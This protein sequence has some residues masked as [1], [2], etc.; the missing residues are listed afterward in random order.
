MKRN[1]HGHDQLH[2]TYSFHKGHDEPMPLSQ[3]ACARQSWQLMWQHSEQ[4]SAEGALCAPTRAT[5]QI[6]P[7]SHIPSCSPL[8]WDRPAPCFPGTRD[9]VCHLT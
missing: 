5:T 9:L 2:G 3:G 4:M 7:K 6:V 8:A 1:R